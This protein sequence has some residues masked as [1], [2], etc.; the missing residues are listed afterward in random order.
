MWTRNNPAARDAAILRSI[1]SLRTING[2]PV[3]QFWQ[4]LDAR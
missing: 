2:K 4:E 3:E 1:R